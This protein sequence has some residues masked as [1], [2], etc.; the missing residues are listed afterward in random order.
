MITKKLYD[1]AVKGKSILVAEASKLNE[2][3]KTLTLGAGS[4]SYKYNQS[5]KVLINKIYV[6]DE[7]NLPAIFINKLKMLNVFE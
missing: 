1:T 7:A 5:Q 3:I 4:W 2:D 6:D